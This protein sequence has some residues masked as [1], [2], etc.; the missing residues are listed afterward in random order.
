M[1]FDRPKGVPLLPLLIYGLALLGLATLNG[2]LLA[3]A[4]PLVC[5]L[6]TGLLFEP[7]GLKLTATRTLSADRAGEQTPITVKL[8]IINE[9]ARLEEA[10]VEDLYP[11]QGLGANVFPEVI[12]GSPAAVVSL[13]PGATITLE[14]TLRG[15]RGAYAFGGA[16]VTVRDYLGIFNRSHVVAAPGHLLI[17]PTFSKIRQV[18]IRP[19]RTRVYSGVIPARQ[20]GP[21]VEFFG[22]REYQPGDPQRWINARA[23]AR[24]TV[25]LFVNEFEQERA[26]DIGLIL[27]GR[28]QSNL[29]SAAESLFEHSVHA[30]ATLADALLDTGNR[31]GLLI[32]RNAIDWTYPGYGKVQR[33]RILRALARADTGD[34][35]GFESLDLIPPRLFPVRS[36]L[37]LISPLLQGD[38]DAL[39]KLRARGYALLVISPDPIPRPGTREQAP[40]GHV[41]NRRWEQTEVVELAM[42]IARLERGLLLRKLRGVGIDV[43]DW[44]VDTPFA[45]VAAA[46]L[47][48]TGRNTLRL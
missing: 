41:G 17:L 47:G 37:V 12:D 10:L 48:R 15:G 43:I 38:L 6:A 28:A 21:G 19:R 46:T 13:D 7:R 40:R 36:Q 16:R 35:P 39:I 3:L 30:T 24:H 1:M 23:T 32:Y 34:R 44:Q 42:R 27:D 4:I 8:A 2:A 22:V 5:Y 11:G 20:G 18:N 9:G 25:G 29:V 33:E 31:V 45:Q 14:Y 26:A